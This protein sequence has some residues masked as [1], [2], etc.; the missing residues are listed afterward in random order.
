MKF[1]LV[2]PAGMELLIGPPGEP[3]SFGYVVGGLRRPVGGDLL[4]Q[5]TLCWTTISEKQFLDKAATSLLHSPK[6]YTERM[7]GSGCNSRAVPPL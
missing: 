4:K 3:R 2:R 6:T 1:I 5:A 7:M